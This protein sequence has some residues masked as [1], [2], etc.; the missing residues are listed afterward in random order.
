MIQ[1]AFIWF[2]HSTAFAYTRE[3]DDE[4]DERLVEN[5]TT[6]YMQFMCIM[7][8][9]EWRRPF[10]TSWVSKPIKSVHD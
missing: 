2:A 4:D 10:H 1:P 6:V 8:R 9:G 3:L 7:E 5:N